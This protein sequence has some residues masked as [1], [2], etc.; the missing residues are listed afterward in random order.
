[1]LDLTP[2]PSCF[3]VRFKGF[4]GVLCVDP[5]LDAAG[6]EDVVFRR[7]QKKFDE[8]E[9]NPAE[10]EVVKY[11]MPSPVCLNRPLIMILDQVSER[12]DR[13][14]HKKIRSRIHWFQETELN[15]LAG[16]MFD[17]DDATEELSTRLSLPIDFQQLHE[18]GF[19]F[20]DEPFFR[21]LLL[22]IHHYQTTFTLSKSKIVLPS[23]LGR[24]MYGVV[25]DTGLL[26]YGQ[27]F[28]QYSSSLRGPS[29]KFIY[30]GRVMVT[31]NPC[32]VAGDVRMFE[33][34]YQRALSHLCD[35]IVFPRY[36]PRPHPDEMAGSDLDGDEYTV[37][38][39]RELFFQH[40]ENAMFF[41]KSKPVEYVTSPTTEDMIDFFLKY[42]SQDSIG[43][44]S[45]AHL[46]MCDRLGLFH[47]TCEN[48]ARKCAVAVDF[49]KTGEP[50]EPLTSFEQSDIAP[51]YMQS[52][53]KP[54]F[55]SSWLLGEL[56]R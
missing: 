41:P 27:V 24:T 47:E 44:M 18:F 46:I 32:H 21:S 43:R 28:I 49:P 15:R 8:D 3:Q 35:V 12:Q 22:A 6:G 20:T 36:G 42:L 17:E 53:V 4:K 26:Q 48:I 23:Y 39:D 10:L 31:K 38:F 25:D 19:T 34:V 16:M 30:T 50:A 56:Y 54:S 33:A 52:S 11:S 1:M 51:D 40:N 2:P 55:R 29:E 14:L 7:S 45:N 37:I 5:S 13:H 9:Q